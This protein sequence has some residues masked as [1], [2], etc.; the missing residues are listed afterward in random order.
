MRS[1][2]TNNLERIQYSAALAVS[3]CWRGTNRQKL[4]D[5]QGWETLYHRRWYRRLCHF[6]KLLLTRSPEYLFSEIPPERQ[7]LYSLRSTN[8][9]DHNIGSTYRFFN[10]YFS[11]TISEWNNLEDGIRKSENIS[12]FKRKLLKM[13]RPQSNSLFGVHDILGSMYLTRLCVQFS[14]L[15]E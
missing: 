3:V 10:T 2:F 5:E 11:N 7:L 9:Y 6:F 4:Y 15:N 14:A 13:I 8:P 1:T 12:I